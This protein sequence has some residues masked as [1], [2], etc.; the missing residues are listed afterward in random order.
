M[1]MVLVKHTVCEGNMP[2]HTD[3]GRTRGAEVIY[4]EVIMPREQ[5]TGMV[6]LM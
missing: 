5:W 2:A 6:L 1:G 3:M 4:D